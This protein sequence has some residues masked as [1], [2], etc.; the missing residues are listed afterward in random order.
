MTPLRKGIAGAGLA[1]LLTLA[2]PALAADDLPRT[3]TVAGLGSIE[4]AP[5][6]ARLSFAAER[7]D[8]SMRAARDAVLRVSRDL[9]ALCQRLGIPEPK[10]RTTG[11]SIQPDYRYQKDGSPPVLAGY[12]VQRQLEVELGNLD[13]LGELI[14]GAIDAGVTQAT[15][16]ELDS[17]RRADRNRDALAAAGEDARRNAERLAAALG[18]RVGPVREVTVGGAQPRPPMPLARMAM[19]DAGMPEAAS[20]TPGALRIEARVT[21][22]FDL[23]TP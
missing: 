9:L 21:V 7:R 17:S 11:L 4:A 22:T 19:A 8:P 12:I 20:Y 1:A 18:A 15:P 14:E 13:R 5:D 10:V 6:L 3:I 23:L 2:G 16:P